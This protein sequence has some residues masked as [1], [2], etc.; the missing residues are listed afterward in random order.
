MALK[1]HTCFISKCKKISNI[2]SFNFPHSFPSGCMVC[3]EKEGGSDPNLS[4][5]NRKNV[6]DPS[7][8]GGQ[9]GNQIGSKFWEVVCEEHG[10]DPTGRYE[11]TS[12]LQLEGVN[13]YCFMSLGRRL[14]TV[15]ACKVCVFF[16]FES[17][18]LCFWNVGFHLLKWCGFLFVVWVFDYLDFVFLSPIRFSV[19]MSNVSYKIFFLWYF[20]IYEKFSA[21]EVFRWRY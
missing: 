13:V 20:F 7:H 1:K 10:I 15:I 16:R 19:N 8:S 4:W 17:L 14:R 5:I 9:C 2:K 21:W 18:T 11:G 3:P 6:R 12:D